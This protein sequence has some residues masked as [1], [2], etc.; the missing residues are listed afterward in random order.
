M[1]PNGINRLRKVRIVGNGLD[2]TFCF[3]RNYIQYKRVGGMIEKIVLPFTRI[4][5]IRVFGRTTAS[6]QIGQFIMLPHIDAR[7]INV[8]CRKGIFI[9]TVPT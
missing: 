3:Y 4:T 5:G 6:Y 9:P 1:R 7:K 2:L 8:G